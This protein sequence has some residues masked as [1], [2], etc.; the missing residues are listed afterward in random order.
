MLQHPR[1]RINGTGLGDL[2]P[3][4]VLEMVESVFSRSSGARATVEIESAESAESAILRYSARLIRSSET[5]E[6]LLVVED[7]T[8]QRVAD[9]AHHAFVTQATH[10]LRTPLTNISL[11]ANML[12]EDH[13]VDQETREKCLNVINQES[14]RLEHIINDMLS[15]AEIEAGSMQL[16]TDDVH[17]LPLIDTIVAEYRVQATEKEQE[18]RLDLPPKL[19]VMQADRGKLTLVLHNLIG[20]AIKYT[21]QGGRITVSADLTD[22]RIQVHVEDTGI[23]I[24]EADLP[25]IF[26]RFYRADDPRLAAITG[27]GLGLALAREV[28]RLHGGDITVDSIIDQGSTFHLALPVAVKVA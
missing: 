7:V 13:E 2:V 11:Y 15:V 12:I 17:L 3:P 14:K 10:E 9:T 27:S 6:A 23:G 1:E 5:S 16:S 28:A 22:D 19:P 4:P 21:P 18:I 24:A 25:N 20:N 8:Q 26:D